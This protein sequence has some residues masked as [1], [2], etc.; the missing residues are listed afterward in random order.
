VEIDGSGY[1]YLFWNGSDWV[2]QGIEVLTLTASESTGTIN[3]STWSVSFDSGVTWYSAAD[4]GGGLVFSPE[5]TG[6]VTLSY[7]NDLTGCVLVGRTVDVSAV[8]GFAFASIFD[9]VSN[10]NF[11]N[12]YITYDGNTYYDFSAFFQSLGG[13]ALLGT[14]GGLGSNGYVYVKAPSLAT[15]ILIFD[16]SNVQRGSISNGSLVFGDG[17]SCYTVTLS[18]NPNLDSYMIGVNF[19]GDSA[20][21]GF[22]PPNPATPSEFTDL[23]AITAELLAFIQTTMGNTNSTVN[24][25]IQ[26]TEIIITVNYV[27]T[28]PAI[29]LFSNQ[30]GEFSSSPYSCP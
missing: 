4:W 2:S 30:F 16:D 26:P 20:N 17:T 29:F 14:D 1:D 23:E 10:N 13:D 3:P 24:V 19:I 28:Y 8:D 5:L 18:P 21:Y 11:S 7:R 25:D 22:I 12:W 6:N 9:S 27:Y 15:D